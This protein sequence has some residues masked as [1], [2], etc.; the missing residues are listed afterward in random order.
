[1]LVFKAYN[2]NIIASRVTI[3][4]VFRCCCSR[5]VG[6]FWGIGISLKVSEGTEFSLKTLGKE[7]LGGSDTLAGTLP[8]FG[9][10]ILSLP[11][12]FRGRPLKPLSRCHY[13]YCLTCM[14]VAKFKFRIKWPFFC[15]QPMGTGLQGGFVEPFF[16]H[17]EII[18]TYAWRETL[19]GVILNFPSL[20]WL[21]LWQK[22][23]FLGGH[24]KRTLNNKWFPL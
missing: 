13:H 11:A 2:S 19:E 24:L 5:A 18:E 15:S 20:L 3:S 21:R 12:F 9:M 8:P 17:W 4:S 14:N 16:N 7:K 10:L 22:I 23:K 1:M 6:Q